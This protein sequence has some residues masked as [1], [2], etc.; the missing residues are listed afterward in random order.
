MKKAGFL[1]VK[2]ISYYNIVLSVA[3]VFGSIV[4]IAFSRN[5]KDVADIFFLLPLFFMILFGIFCFFSA[6]K[7][8]RHKKIGRVSLLCCCI[9]QVAFSIK[10]LI[11]MSK[12]TSSFS[13]WSIIMF[14][15]G[16]WGIWYLNSKDGKKWVNKMNGEKKS[17]IGSA[18][19]I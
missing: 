2:L 11:I 17:E 18:I 10:G 7:Y 14:L 15:F 5:I 12:T 9:I 3:F 6:L 1:G 16:A 19:D 4:M 8:L 13:F